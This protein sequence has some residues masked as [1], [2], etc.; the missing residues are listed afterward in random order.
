MC[1]F[2]SSVWV[3]SVID[4]RFASV[5]S[6]EDS[7]FPR[8]VWCVCVCV[9]LCVIY[10]HSLMWHPEVWAAVG[11]FNQPQSKNILIR[12]TNK[13]VID[14]LSEPTEAQR[15][16]LEQRTSSSSSSSK[17]WTSTRFCPTWS[18]HLCNITVC[19]ISYMFTQTVWL[20]A[21]LNFLWHLK[22]SGF[23]LRS[24]HTLISV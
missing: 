1:L 18:E 10:T 3:W 14:K 16:L 15:P 6:Q 7:R 8:N 4:D 24:S 21:D 2:S 22:S 17:P 20:S 9:C 23:K 13:T 12:S 5:G 11:W 19:F